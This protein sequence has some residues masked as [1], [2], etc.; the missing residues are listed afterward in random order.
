MADG[1][2]SEASQKMAPSFFARRRRGEMKATPAP[3]MDE[4]SKEEKPSADPE[5]KGD[6]A[7]QRSKR[8][9]RLAMTLLEA[10][11]I[12]ENLKKSG[13]RR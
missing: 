8:D 1:C 4:K 11:V 12:A 9:V 10:E 5:G 7:G 6:E 2:P 13:T 3:A